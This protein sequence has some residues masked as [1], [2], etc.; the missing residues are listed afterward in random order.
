MKTQAAGSDALYLPDFCTT[1]ATLATVLIVELTALLLTLARQSAAIDFWVRPAVVFRRVLPGAEA[2][3]QNRSA[4]PGRPTHPTQA[5]DH[6][7][8][9]RQLTFRVPGAAPSRDHQPR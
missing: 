1:R 8:E 9:A 5:Q 7:V 2:S 4:D 3:P 6:Q